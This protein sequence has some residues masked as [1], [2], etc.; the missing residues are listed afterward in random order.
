[1]ILTGW[2]EAELAQASPQT[3]RA[4]HHRIEASH[5]WTP[6][7]RQVYQTSIPTGMSAKERGQLVADRSRAQKIHDALFPE[8]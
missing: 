2:T 6:Y 4:L 7:A 1:M 3:V 5:M 8:D